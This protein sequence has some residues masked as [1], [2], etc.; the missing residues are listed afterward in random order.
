MALIIAIFVIIDARY[1]RIGEPE[2]GLAT[3]TV[4]PT[5]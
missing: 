3:A 2:V 4:T 5:A 1:A